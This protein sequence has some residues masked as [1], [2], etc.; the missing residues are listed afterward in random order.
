[1]EQDIQTMA[2]ENETL[3]T[4]TNEATDTATEESEADELIRL[5]EE[6]R[7][8]NERL[9]AKTAEAEKVA[10]QIGDFYSAFPDVQLKSV[11][12]DVWESVRNGNSLAASYA[13]YMHKTS[14]NNARIKEQNEKNAFRSA[15]HI[16]NSAAGEYFTPDE[17][18]KMSRS[19]VRANYSK[20][21]E[22]MKKWI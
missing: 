20:I 15:G 13:L 14:Q 16:G 5:R 11:P 2:A 6:V 8:L 19:E 22:S 21:V 10:A 1:M 9:E 4:G 3:L 18:K 12:D 7:S 17:V